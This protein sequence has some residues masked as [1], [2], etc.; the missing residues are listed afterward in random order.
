MSGKQKVLLG[1]TLGALLLC[2]A[3]ALYG[4]F[5]LW[6]RVTGHLS[7][8]LENEIA[9]TVERTAGYALALDS[10]DDGTVRVA[11]SDLDFST[12][13]D[14]TGESGYDIT[15]NDVTIYNAF[16]EIRP[17]GL[18]VYLSDMELHGMPAIVD[19]QFVL[20]DVTKES[21]VTGKLF[22]ADV[23]ESGLTRGINAALANAS[24]RPVDVA[25]VNNELYLSVESAGSSTIT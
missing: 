3:G 7:D 6:P 24:L 14:D 13:H 2:S 20:H 23:L 18:H 5:E 15:N 11:A 9:T 21:G 25:I 12:V 4:Y 1:I 8:A 22:E 19:G 17:D 10:S 16:V